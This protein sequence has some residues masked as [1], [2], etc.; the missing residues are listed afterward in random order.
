M[1]K[2]YVVCGNLQEVVLADTPE[3]ACSRAIMRR[4]SD[5]VP[6]RLD[7]SCFCV[8]QRGFRDLLLAHSDDALEEV[9]KYLVW[10]NKIIRCPFV[11]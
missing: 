10:V 7:S 9:P 3:D 6:T 4:L 5:G 11:E 2:Y 1:N 8:D